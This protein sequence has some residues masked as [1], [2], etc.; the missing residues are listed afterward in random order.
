MAAIIFLWA[1]GVGHNASLACG[2]D[3]NF[4]TMAALPISLLNE[5]GGSGTLPSVS[6]HPRGAATDKY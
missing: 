6:R 2:K 4:V 3:K 1:D 5:T